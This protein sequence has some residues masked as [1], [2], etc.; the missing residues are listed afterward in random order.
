[1]TNSDTR[2][3]I[4]TDGACR[5]N[6]GPGGWAAIIQREVKGEIVKTLPLNGFAEATTNN[7]MEMTAALRAL[8][9]IKLD[10]AAPI[11]I[12]TDSKYLSD[13]MTEW[14]PKWKL[15]GWKAKGGGEVKNRDLWEALDFVVTGKNVKWE[16]VRG[17]DGDELNERADRLANDA[18]DQRGGS[19]R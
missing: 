3:I 2:I 16:W 8:H 7:Q 1:M 12:R 15:R 9:R 10:E 19:S 11:I 4:T 6:P 18:I 5:G 13:G 17:H 14:L